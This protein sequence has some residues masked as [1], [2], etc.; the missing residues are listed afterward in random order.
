FVDPRNP[1][2]LRIN[3][4]RKQYRC[5]EDFAD[6][7]VSELIATIE[8]TYPVSR[9]KKD[10]VIQGSSAGGLNAACFGIMATE[11]FGGLSM[12]SPGDLRYLRRL[13]KE[14]A[15]QEAFPVKVF[16][17]VGNSSDNRNAVRRFKAVLDKKGFDINFIQNSKEHGWRNW[18]PLVDDALLT[19]FAID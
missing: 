10:R 11:E 17:S 8:N 19:F 16:M 6:F 4:R 2:D 15:T 7:F 9:N 3:R 1:D 18:R 14:Y 12:H 13:N 5:N